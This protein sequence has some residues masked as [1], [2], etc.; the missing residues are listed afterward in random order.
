MAKILVVEDEKK[1]REGL[2]DNLLFEGYEVDAVGDG[3]KGLER[4][5]A[6]EYDL[7]LLDVML[8]S[9]SGFDILRSLRERGVKTPVIMVTARGEEIDRVLGLELG[10][11]DYVLKPFS[12]REMLARVK[13]VLRRTDQTAVPASR[14]AIGR[15]IADVE[16]CTALEDGKDTAMTV[17]EFEILKYLW[18]H[19]GQTVTREQLLNDVWGYEA[20]P[21]TRTVD[22]FIV[23][24]R[25]KIE[26][27]PSRPKHILTVHGAGYRLIP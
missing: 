24:L 17:K 23:R 20:A 2:K 11:D 22:N 26:K 8:P 7:M 19:Q 6:E 10:A 9:M 15:L 14:I 13:A 4:A 18:N 12:L 5:I 27:D 16:A 3:A 25:Q 21:T 1:M